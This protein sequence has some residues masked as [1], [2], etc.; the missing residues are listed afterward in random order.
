MSAEDPRTTAGVPFL[1]PEDETLAASATAAGAMAVVVSPEGIVLHH[2]DDKPWIPHPGCWSLFGG[3]AEP[4][5][6][7]AET[8]VRELSEELGLQQARCRPMW[9]VVDTEGDGRVLTI[10]EARTLLHTDQMSLAEGQGIQAF[11]L[12]EALS[13]RLAPFCRRVLRRYALGQRT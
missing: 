9:R 4:G 8:V 3:A 6:E 5:E 12:N 13:L 10:F 1:D 7:P 2:R 11:D